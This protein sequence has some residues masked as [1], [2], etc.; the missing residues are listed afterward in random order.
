[1]QVSLSLS[2]SMYID[3]YI[4]NTMMYMFVYST[5]G[6][7]LLFAKLLCIC[8][9][10]GEMDTRLQRLQDHCKFAF[11]V[12]ASWQALVFI[13]WLERWKTARLMRSHV[14][15]PLALLCC[16]ELLL[17]CFSDVAVLLPRD[18]T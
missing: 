4:H 15:R 18:P 11:G 14:S 6:S 3:T 5:D 2:L 13:A 8:Q 17:C 12:L 7:Q 10:Q 16:F 1:M 9:R